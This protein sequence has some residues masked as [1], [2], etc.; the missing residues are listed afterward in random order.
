[1]NKF[2][3][4]QEGVNQTQENKTKIFHKTIKKSLKKLQQVVSNILNE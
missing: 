3:L 4:F 2:N 1:M